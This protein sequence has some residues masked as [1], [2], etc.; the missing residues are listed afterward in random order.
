VQR[1]ADAR[2]RCTEERFLGALGRIHVG[3]TLTEVCL[4]LLRYRRVVVVVDW[5]LRELR[6]LAAVSLSIEHWSVRQKHVEVWVAGAPMQEHLGGI[7]SFS[8]DT[9]NIVP[10]GG[11]GSSDECL[12]HVYFLK[13]VIKVLITRWHLLAQMPQSNCQRY[14]KRA[15]YDEAEREPA[16]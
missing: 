3:S 2:G 4:R 14:R 8:S 10:Q 5:S 16:A 13:S 1:G 15:W 9:P 11:W 7:C 6:I 12:P